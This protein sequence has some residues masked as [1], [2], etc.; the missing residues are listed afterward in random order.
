MKL[1]SK[2]L[3]FF[4]TN[5]YIKLE[6]ILRKKHF[7]SIKKII[8]P[9]VNDKIENWFDEGLISHK[10][11]KLNFWQRF[12][13]AWKDAGKPSFRRN[14]NKWLINNRMYKLLKDKVFID[15]AYQ[16][17]DTKEISVHGIFNTRPQLPAADFAKAP[18]HQDS[19][20]WSMNYGQKYDD[21]YKSNVLTFFI[22]LQNVGTN[23]GCLSL[24]SLKDTKNKLFKA[25]E[26]DFKNT[27]Y[28]GLSKNDIL[29]YK[30]KPIPMKV[31]DILIFNHLVPHGTNPQKKQHIR[32]SLDIRYEA[33]HNATG[34]GKK[35]GF[36]ASSEKK[37][38]IT[39]RSSWV[40][41]SLGR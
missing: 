10:Y 22:P 26:Y 38:N 28:L 8:D 40:N 12:L 30:K 23:S 5:G 18:W 35:F 7:D 27:G 36:I 19:Q 31:G 1:K 3:K 9:W 11:S 32:W 34:L 20:Y 37:Q 6:K 13:V 33:T 21:P 16:L 17:L 24:M 29:K 25:V 41:K 15:L 4:K 14:P 2:Q 39:K